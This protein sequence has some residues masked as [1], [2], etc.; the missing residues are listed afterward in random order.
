MKPLPT[1][2][3]SSVHGPGEDWMHIRTASNFGYPIYGNAWNGHLA[4]L[5]KLHNLC[6]DRG[7]LSPTHCW[8][9]DV[10]DGDAWVVYDN[11][12]DDDAELRGRPIG[13]RLWDITQKIQQLGILRPPHTAM[14]VLIGV[15]GIG[16]IAFTV[17]RCST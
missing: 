5:P 13:D 9:G 14:I 6:I 1:L 16:T 8:H 15:A 12:Q 3:S 4:Y 7:D 17:T 11:Y 10:H 2:L